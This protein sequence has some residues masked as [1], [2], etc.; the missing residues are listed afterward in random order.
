MDAKHFRKS[1]DRLAGLTTATSIRLWM[2][3]LDFRAAYYNP[4]VDPAHPA[5][6]GQTIYV[7]WHE[8]ILFPFYLRGHCNL[9]MLVSRH[10]DADILTEVA[11]LLGFDFVRGS[12]FRGGSTALREL[13]RK[14]ESMNLAITPDG[15]RGPRRRLA[16]GPIYLA[17]K[18]RMPLVV[19]GFGYDRPWRFSTWDR[20]AVPRPYSRARM[21]ASPEILVPGDLDRDGIE[22]YRRHV[23]RLLTRFTLEAEAWAASGTRKFQEV[24]LRKQSAAVRV[25]SDPPRL[26]A[27]PHTSRQSKLS[28]Y[29]ADV[30]ETAA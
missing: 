15:P 19:L 14:S 8:Y 28:R 27:G 1:L 6:R 26:I 13:L 4:A 7:F 5:H 22:H 18:L 16:Q 3:T 30:D 17:S 23:Q 9:S 25:R 12:S 20:F 24:P 2:S 21:V 10:R 29:A 11:G